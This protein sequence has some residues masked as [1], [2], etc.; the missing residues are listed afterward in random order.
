MVCR[1]VLPIY[2]DTLVYY[3]GAVLARRGNRRSRTRVV[4]SR[5]CIGVWCRRGVLLRAG[6]YC[7]TSRRSLTG[8]SRIKR[9]KME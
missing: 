7:R 9:V 2:V 8:P 1:V 4:K 3:D 6:E 5:I